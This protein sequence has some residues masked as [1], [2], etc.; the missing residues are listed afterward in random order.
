MIAACYLRLSWKGVSF[1]EG[2]A[3]RIEPRINTD[4]PAGR[5]VDTDK[6]KS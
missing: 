6:C 5:R 2:E 3:Q 1:E 4:L